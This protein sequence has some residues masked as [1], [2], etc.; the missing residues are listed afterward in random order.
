MSLV[1]AKNRVQTAP[2][3][4]V[5]DRGISLDCQAQGCPNRWH[6][7][8]GNGRLCSFHDRAPKHLWPQI[9][10]EQ[11]EAQTD[12][13]RHVTELQDQTQRM[14]R[15]QKLAILAKLRDLVTGRSFHPRAWAAS[16]QRRRAAGERLSRAQRQCL[17]E[18]ERRTG[19]EK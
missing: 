11:L 6:V 18:Y 8:M 3:G 4:D 19:E 13:A 5:D 17:A 14:T 16:L 1:K 10:Q 9:T 2:E 7:D 15:S 12:R